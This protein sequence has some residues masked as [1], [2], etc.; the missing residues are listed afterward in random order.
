[1]S[2]RKQVVPKTTQTIDSSYN[3]VKQ[4]E[5]LKR[6]IQWIVTDDMFAKFKQHGNSTWQASSMITLVVLTAWMPNSQL[7]EAFVK[8]GELSVN[9]FGVMAV[10]TYQGMMR[11][12]VNNGSSLLL[13]VWARLQFLMEEISPE[14]FRIGGWLPLAVDGSRY[15]TPRTQ[16]NERAFSAKRYGKGKCAKSR[17]KWKNKSR[18]SKKVSPIKPQ[19]WMTLI[20]HMGLKL[21]WCWKTGPSTSSERHHLIEMLKSMVFPEK[22]LFC[23]DAGFVGYELWSTIMDQGHS[24]LIRVGGNVRL[25]KN[26][27]VARVKGDGIVYLWP[28]EI[29]RKN[30][31]PLILRLIE[32]KSSKGTMYLVTNILDQ[33]KLS[34]ATVRKL[35]PLRWGIEL[36]FR[37][38]KQTYGLAKLRSRNSNHALVEL[39][40]SLVALT[41]I[42][43]LAIKE[44]I[45]LDIPPEHSS[46]SEAIKAIRYAIDNWCLTKPKPLDLHS[47]LQEATKDQYQRNSSKQARYR[48]ANPDKPSATKPKI[49]QA[50]AKQKAKYRAILQAA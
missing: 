49:I 45:A 1:M 36:Q 50:T 3:E 5:L 4:G 24:F 31:P 39:D 30:R 40:W 19:V 41:M 35:Y 10:N 42:Q 7:T 20:W 12:M 33:K 9:L 15:T 28:D 38:A 11:A 18:R 29:A 13:I 37:T 17:R 23:G 48:P 21:P 6:A 26:L 2:S 27:G 44:Q 14:H 8:A 43:L 47:R 34:C 16:S 32:V 25:L 22:T 46:V